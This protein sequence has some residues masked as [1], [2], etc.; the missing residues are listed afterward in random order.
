VKACLVVPMATGMS[1]VLTLLTLKSLRHTRVLQDMHTPRTHA[2]HKRQ[3]NKKRKTVH[4]IDKSESTHTQTH[5]NTP[6]RRHITDTKTSPHIHTHTHIHTATSIP[7]QT[8]THTHTQT[9]TQ[10]Q[11]QTQTKRDQAR[12]VIWPRID[13]K[14]C[15]KAIGTAGCSL[16]SSL[17][18][19][20]CCYY[21][22]TES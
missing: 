2:K 15:L 20:Y 11:T 18:H 7:T 13:Q 22:V 14:T 1:I 8:H 10:T 19:T 5:T 3:T 17:A 12:Y 4:A 6:Q 9:R 21:Y 16:R